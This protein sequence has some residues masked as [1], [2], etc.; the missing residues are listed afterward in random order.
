[1]APRARG[2]ARAGTIAVVL[3]DQLDRASPALAGLDPACDTVLMVEA[4]EESAHV[5]SH[6]ARIA[7]FFAAMRHFAE[8]LRRDGVPLAYL[9]IGTH[10]HPSLESAWRAEIAARAP[11]RVVCVEPGD[12]RV[13]AMLQRACGEAGVALD[14]LP[15]PRFLCSLE[16]FERW[17]GERGSLRMEF[18]YRWMRSR[19]GVLMDGDE[20]AGGR[21]NYDAENR[22]GFGAKGPGPVPAPPGFAPDAITRGAIAD[23]ARHF[24]GHPGALDRFVWPVTPADA[25]RALDAFLHE[26]L[27]GFG[28]HQDAMWTGVPFGWHSLLSPAMNLKLLD[29]RE[30]VAAAEAEWRAGRADLPSVEGF[31]RQV[32]GW[33]EFVRGVYW[34][35]MPGLADAN[36]YGHERPLPAWY[37]TGDTGMNCMRETVGQTLAHGYAHHIQRLMITGNFALLAGVRPQAAC[38]WYLAIYVDAVDW[39]ERPN[40]AGMALY[41][42]GGRFTSKP[43]AASGQYVKRMSNYCAGCRYDPAKREGEGAC[44]VTVLFWDFVIRHESALASEPRTAIMA[45]NARRIGADERTRIRRGA[46]R[47]LDAVDAL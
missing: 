44:P 47:L 29:P 6:K 28:R 27:P 2:P 7:L 39:V 37:W 9:S 43:Y 19:T 5:W 24:P 38:D 14:V 31:V 11:A 10:P 17:A 23:V 8:D 4:P 35:F 45:S 18:F 41:A 32:L 13:L 15:D 3:G 21:W 33:R 12:W 1:M 46:G 40:T 16:S 20:P 22:R 25:R 30:V 42:D 26:R 36:H 34:R